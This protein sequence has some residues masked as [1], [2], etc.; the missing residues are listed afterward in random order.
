LPETDRHRSA[1]YPPAAVAIL[2]QGY[3]LAPNSE[4]S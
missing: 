1:S 3:L 4:L 2:L